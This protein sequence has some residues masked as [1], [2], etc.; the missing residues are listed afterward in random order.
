MARETALI[1]GATGLVG[2][3]L[4]AYFT[5][6]GNVDVIGVARR[7]QSSAGMRW[8]AID[9]TNAG[10]CRRRLASLA[11]VTQVYYEIGRAHV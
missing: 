10:E 2:R 5:A 8:I 1:A 3:T 11:D 7:P 9:L 6:Q 4:S